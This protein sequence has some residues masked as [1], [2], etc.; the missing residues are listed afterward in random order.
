M[1]RRAANGRCQDA[2]RRNT[3][4]VRP[5]IEP[6]SFPRRRRRSK[7]RSRLRR[8]ATRSGWRT[9]RM[10]TTTSATR[11]IARV[12][13]S[14]NPLRRRPLQKW[15]DAVKAYETALQLRGDDA[16]SKYNRDFVKRKIDALQQPPPD[17]GGGGGGGPAVVAAAAAKAA[18]AV[19][20]GNPRHRRA[21]RGNPLRQDRASLHRPDPMGRV[22]RRPKTNRPTTAAAARLRRQA[23]AAAA[24]PTATPATGAGNRRHRR[25][26]NRRLNTGPASASGRPTA[27]GAISPQPTQP[28]Q[29]QPPSAPPQAAGSN[30]PSEGQPEDSAD[31]P[32]RRAK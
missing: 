30:S 2:A 16:D 13:S 15:T 1:R 26:S 12:S 24:R 8:R 10:L 27:S 31:T 28:G 6:D 5:R 11:C 32:A 18:V 23:S 17:G 9:R 21:G 19:A 14:R 3:T 4:R 7:N 29:G 20:R 25:A 22:S